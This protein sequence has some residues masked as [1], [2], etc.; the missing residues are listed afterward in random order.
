[1][2]ILASTGPYYLKVGVPE[3]LEQA[4]EG[5][6]RE[7][8]RQQ[9]EHIYQFAAAHFEKLLTLHRQQQAH[10]AGM[11]P[12]STQSSEKAPPGEP[13]IEAQENKDDVQT[14]EAVGVFAVDETTLRNKRDAADQAEVGNS[15]SDA[16]ASGVGATGAV[17][18]ATAEYGDSSRAGEKQA[19]FTDTEKMPAGSLQERGVSNTKE[20]SENVG[21]NSN[22]I[23]KTELEEDKPVDLSIPVTLVKQ[24][25]ESATEPMNGVKPCDN[26]DSAVRKNDLASD[27]IM[28]EREET[29]SVTKCDINEAI[30]LE[31]QA[32]QDILIVTNTSIDGESVQSTEENTKT[33]SIEP[34]TYANQSNQVTISRTEDVDHGLQSQE[35]EAH[36]IGDDQSSSVAPKEEILPIMCE[37]ALI[38]DANKQ[39]VVNMVEKPEKEAVPNSLIGKV[40]EVIEELEEKT[41]V[42]RSDEPILELDEK[43]ANYSS[44]VDSAEEALSRSLN[45][46]GEK[47][48]KSKNE[49]VEAET[50]SGDMELKCS[51]NILPSVAA[52]EAVLNRD[53]C[54]SS[55]NHLKETSQAKQ[56]N[57]S[58]KKDSTRSSPL[59]LSEEGIPITPISMDGKTSDISEKL[60]K[61]YLDEIPNMKSIEE[62]KLNEQGKNSFISE[63]KENTDISQSDIFSKDNSEEL[64]SKC[65]S[66]E[67]LNNEKNTAMPLNLSVE[68]NKNLVEQ[69]K[70]GE[71]AEQELSRTP[72][73]PSTE[74]ID[75]CSINSSPNNLLNKTNEIVEPPYNDPSAAKK[76]ESEIL[77]SEHNEI[78]KENSEKPLLNLHSENSVTENNLLSKVAIKEHNNK[79]IRSSETI[80]K[81]ISSSPLKRSSESVESNRELQ[82]STEETASKSPYNKILDGTLENTDEVSSAKQIQNVFLSQPLSDVRE[83]VDKSEN[84]CNFEN[85]KEIITNK[86]P[87]LP[88]EIGLPSDV[89]PTENIT[90]LSSSSS[91][92]LVTEIP[93]YE[94]ALNEASTKEFSSDASE[95]VEINIENTSSLKTAEIDDTS[96]SLSELNELIEDNVSIPLSTK[97]EDYT[98][99]KRDSSHNNEYYEEDDQ[100]PLTAEQAGGHTSSRPLSVN[101]ETDKNKSKTFTS[102]YS[103]EHACP[104]RLISDASVTVDKP[105]EET[106]LSNSLDL[107]D[108]HSGNSLEYQSS[109]SSQLLAEHEKGVETEIKTNNVICKDDSIQIQTK[110]VTSTEDINKVQ[111]DDPK[112]ISSKEMEIITKIVSQSKAMAEEDS[113]NH[114][115]KDQQSSK[116]E[117]LFDSSL[118]TTEKE[119]MVPFV[120]EMC[121]NKVIK[122]MEA[123]E[124]YTEEVDK[125]DS[126]IES[127]PESIMT[128]PESMGDIELSSE[129]SFGGLIEKSSEETKSEDIK[130][131]EHEDSSLIGK[132][133][134]ESVKDTLVQKNN[135][136]NTDD[137]NYDN[138]EY[139]DRLSKPIINGVEHENKDD[140]LYADAFGRPV[141]TI[142]LIESEEQK[143][144][145]SEEDNDV[146]VSPENKEEVC[147]VAETKE[148]EILGTKELSMNDT[149][150]ETTPV[151]EGED[152]ASESAA[153]SD[154]VNLRHRDDGRSDSGT[155]Q[156]RAD[157]MVAE[158]GSE[159]ESLATVSAA[160]STDGTR[161]VGEEDHGAGAPQSANTRD[162]AKEVQE[163]ALNIA[164]T[165]IQASFRGFQTRQAL[166]T[167]PETT[168]VPTA[169][170][171]QDVADQNFSEHM[172]TPDIGFIPEDDSTIETPH[173]A[174]SRESADPPRE[175]QQPSGLTDSEDKT[176]A[177]P[178][179]TED[180]QLTGRTDS[181]GQH[182]ADPTDSEDRQSARTSDC[183]DKQPARPS[184]TKDRQ[185]SGRT[186]SEDKHP[187]KLSD[188]GNR[189][190][191]GRTDSKDKTPARLSDTED[192][193]LSGR[194]DSEDKQP[195]RPSD[196]KDRQ[197]SGRTDSEDKQSAKLSDTENRQ[198]SGRTDTEDKQ[199]AKLSDTEDRQP[200]EPTDSDDEDLASLQRPPEC[201]E[202]PEHRGEASQDGSEAPTSEDV[203]SSPS[204]AATKIQSCF[205][206]YMVRKNKHDT[207]EDSIAMSLTNEPSIPDSQQSFGTFSTSNEDNGVRTSG[208]LETAVQR[209][210]QS[211]LDEVEE[212]VGSGPPLQMDTSIH[213][214]SNTPNLNERVSTEMLVS[215]ENKL[216]KAKETTKGLSLDN[217][218]DATAKHEQVA[219]K[220][221]S[222]QETS[223]GVDEEGR[224]VRV[225]IE[226]ELSEAATKIQS[227]Y[228]GYRAR[229][230]LTR[231]DAFQVP[232]TSTS[233]AASADSD[234]MA[235]CEIRASGEFH[236][237]MVLPPGEI[238]NLTNGENTSA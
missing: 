95:P 21:D 38:E 39:G 230:R 191:S 122:A 22:I 157:S 159:L 99:L 104:S 143:R 27:I 58:E 134:D 37:S 161:L 178:T 91:S 102:V 59:E 186:D 13:E 47:Y 205:R 30:I 96:R 119:E 208:S 128:V 194:T 68:S 162:C 120:N 216:N 183:K 25:D 48:N 140:N 142:N 173:R 199:P 85:E 223:T 169:G 113:A 57:D 129:S 65:L 179:D 164:A 100:L 181:E 1:M 69:Q 76:K 221:L 195:A 148:E 152:S 209:Q 86:S 118:Q 89:T 226:K 73:T 227:N 185:L 60:C 126:K 77:T 105:V 103:A 229:Q 117:E 53:I 90:K 110:T 40:G 203:D 64:A 107:T 26:N 207:V 93:S 108:G 3:G 176:P 97:C 70:I 131:F 174:A 106:V 66:T 222:L 219:Q 235:E 46:I 11:S 193:Q 150:L 228:R 182:P 41:N 4:I 101:S 43:H 145:D 51:E 238:S 154:S 8:I 234:K 212:L 200:A 111:G 232:T 81:E 201:D 166:H 33:N 31:E 121:N 231:E 6:A 155:S 156:S 135:T 36:V 52:E 214:V 167:S 125:E 7:V 16:V 196:T 116:V 15:A 133:I 94:E 98:V 146:I 190:L 215:S 132:L 115:D 153:G 220:A 56:I 211:T 171:Q 198:L 61:D 67:K 18:V 87:S 168:Q 79:K 45:E 63:T 82:S 206:G 213:Q 187:A 218:V 184:D 204:S 172:I 124:N 84:L 5:L 35:S 71:S 163:A 24:E 136:E 75:N 210:K 138:Q 217:T 151:D 177:E 189:Q 20:V 130:N 147:D 62:A 192:R 78:V 54:V 170:S 42:A 158:K 34:D 28:P 237:M 224:N 17:V 127:N 23:N 197:L 2:K 225:T 72:I 80:R 236:D 137:G 123:V 32:K 160:P 165:T 139:K 144:S 149:L 29:S 188:T 88:L 112:S 202:L 49:A 44:S 19:E 114:T 141:P 92:E 55:E 74:S 180:Q 10:N 12:S 50:L 83:D 109:I 9:P 233:S 14:A 175:D